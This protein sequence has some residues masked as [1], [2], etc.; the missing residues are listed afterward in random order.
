MVQ[1]FRVQ[2]TTFSSQFGLGQGALTYQM[3]TGTNHHHGD[4]FEINRNI[5]FNLIG[6]LNGPNFNQTYKFD[7]APTDR[8]NNYG[9]TVGGSLSIP[10]VYDAKDR[11]FF[12]YTQEWCKQVE[13]NTSPGTVPT[14]REAGGDF[15]DYFSDYVD[16][17]GNVIP[18]F[19]PQ[20]V[21]CARL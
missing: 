6:I 13:E 4:L 5:Y 15:S 11:T 12:H 21:H 7:K 20:R 3:V 8:E 2:Q 10:H 9:F 14:T 19:V 17:N 16:A 18:I 1:E